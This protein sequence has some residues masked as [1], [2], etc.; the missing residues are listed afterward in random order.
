MS[1]DYVNIL[2][3]H[4]K[5]VKFGLHEDAVYLKKS[6]LSYEQVTDE[7]NKSGKIPANCSLS[8]SAVR[9]FFS[10]LP[11]VTKEIVKENKGMLVEIVNTQFDII[12]EVTELYG[13]T[14]NI[15]ADLEERAAEKDRG[16]NPYQYKAV[17]SEMR[18][19]LRHMTDIQKEVNDYD[20]VRKF[21]E[22]VI[23]TVSEECPAALGKIAAKLK[24]TKGTQWF[25]DILRNSGGDF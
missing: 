11:E 16:V 25:T 2:T 12:K 23:K 10:D 21:M 1:D 14:K 22:I 17:C 24:V 7:L 5:V 20:N 8:V 3:K 4:S 19:L 15:L 18:E 9:K 13:R 6:G